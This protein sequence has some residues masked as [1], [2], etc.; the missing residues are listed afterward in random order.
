MS[1]SASQ[2]VATENASRSSM[3]D[4]YVRT[5]RSKK[6]PSS[7]KS[8]I[9]GSAGGICAPER[10]SSAAFI[11]RVLA[12]GE[13]GWKPMPSSRIEATV[14]CSSIEPECG[15]VVPATIFRSVDFPAPFSPISPSAPPRG[16]SKETSRR[17]W[18]SRWR[19][20]RRRIS[21]SRSAAE[22]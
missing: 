8:R 17:A 10:P 19:G 1:T 2:C 6:S 5:G 9:S 4:E 14:P 16:S 13:L 7:E 11:A 12:A 22:S 18:K 15:L 21:R 20:R 3:P